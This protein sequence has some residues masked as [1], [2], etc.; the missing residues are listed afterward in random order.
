MKSSGAGHSGDSDSQAPVQVQKLEAKWQ[1][2]EEERLRRRQLAAEVS[3]PAENA[4]VFW[5]V[6][7]ML[8]GSVST[9][10]PTGHGQRVLCRSGSEAKP[11]WPEVRAQN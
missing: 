5:Q 2:R 7:P 8:H 4:H 11:A 1:E 10:S 6:S 3:D 9:E